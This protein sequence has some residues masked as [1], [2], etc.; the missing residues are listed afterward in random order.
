MAKVISKP[1]KVII[2]L[3]E[4]LKPSNKKV[5]ELIQLENTYHF[6]EER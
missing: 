4:K 3:Q 6:T 1:N 5:N 2:G